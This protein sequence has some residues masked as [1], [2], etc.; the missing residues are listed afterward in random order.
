MQILLLGELICRREFWQRLL[1]FFLVTS[2]GCPQGAEQHQNGRQIWVIENPSL[3]N[4]RCLNCIYAKRDKT[5]I[6]PDVLAILTQLIPKIP[7]C[8]FVA[9]HRAVSI[10][11]VFTLFQWVNSALSQ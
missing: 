8:G 9:F 10:I 2:Q 6:T 5:F 1:S 4:T 11:S 7:L 3:F